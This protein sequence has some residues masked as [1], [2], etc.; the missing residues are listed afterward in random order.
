MKTRRFLAF[1]R[2]KKGI[3][4]PVTAICIVMLLTIVAVVIDLGRLYVIKA[5]LQNAADAGASAGAQALF[6]DPNQALLIKPV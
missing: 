2:D 6:L 1:L 3:A 5:E 4:V